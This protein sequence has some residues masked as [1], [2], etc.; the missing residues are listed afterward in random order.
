[1]LNSIQSGM[2]NI[3]DEMKQRLQAPFTL[4]FVSAFCF[5]NYGLFL[6]LLSGIE[7]TDKITRVGSNLDPSN[8]LLLP[9]KDAFILFVFW[10]IISFL[11]GI[12]WEWKLSIQSGITTKIRNKEDVILKS[13]HES[14]VDRVSGNLKAD[15]KSLQTELISEKQKVIDMQTLLAAEKGE[16]AIRSK[17]I[18][19]MQKEQE[20]ATKKIQTAYEKNQADRYKLFSLAFRVAM[21]K[22]EGGDESLKNLRFSSAAKQIIES[23]QE[24]NILKV[25]KKVVI[26][27]A[28]SSFQ[29][30]NIK[31]WDELETI[32]KRDFSITRLIA[33]MEENY[34]Y[35]PV[36]DL[37]I[38]ELF[39]FLI[40]SGYEVIS[41]ASQQ[42]IEAD[43]NV[44]KK[45]VGELIAENP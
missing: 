36:K 10:N 27:S 42:Q 9:I 20:L 13:T 22:R 38:Y 34:C 8:L 31:N 12:I 33:V 35:I 21:E 41:L 25:K 30:D 4:F 29:P 18:E 16:A 40:L 7:T 2:E 26:N 37:S 45:Q 24:I 5:H 23:K 6:W 14:E 44:T 32:L 43:I 19:D 3:S 1:M 15:I 28:E 39:G 17:T 11:T